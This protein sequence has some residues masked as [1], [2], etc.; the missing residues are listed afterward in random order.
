MPFSQRAARARQS[1]GLTARLMAQEGRQA[2]GWFYLSFANERRFLGAVIVWAHGILTAIES[3]A[4]MGIDPGGEVL[5]Y[6]IARQQI[7]RVPADLRN[8]L[9][10][11]AEVRRRLSGRR[12]DE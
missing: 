11:E 8:R 5:C 2:L 10:T 4:A 3:A 12:L 6:A 7:G 9:L 1:S